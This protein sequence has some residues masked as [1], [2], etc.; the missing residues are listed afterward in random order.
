MSL[1]EEKEEGETNGEEEMKLIEA[2]TIQHT[3]ILTDS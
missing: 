3:K 1:E 2:M